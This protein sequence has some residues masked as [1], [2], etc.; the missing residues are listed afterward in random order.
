MKIVIALIVMVPAYLMVPAYA[1]E[2]RFDG[3]KSVE[4]FWRSKGAPDHVAAGIADNVNRESSFDP[5]RPGDGGTSLGLYQHHNERMRTL[6]AA[7]ENEQ[8]F[9]DV[10]GADP[11]AAAHWN[12]IKHASSRQEAA[13]LWA[14]YFERCKECRGPNRAAPR[15]SPEIKTPA[16]A[17]PAAPAD[18]FSTESE[19]GGSS[20]L[21][22][23]LEQEK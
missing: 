19:E 15:T 16:L 23:N 13:R 21:I 4:D 14:R 9:R 10:M 6:L 22:T 12:E 2:Q 1:E 11:V 18:P 5:A 3:R 20:F 7:V 8:A 17:M